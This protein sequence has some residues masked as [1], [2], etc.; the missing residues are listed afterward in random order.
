MPGNRKIADKRKAA[1][2]GLLLLGGCM[3]WGCDEPGEIKIP[4]ET[5]LPTKTEAP[6]PTEA[7]KPAEPEPTAALTGGTPTP[8]L[9]E[10]PEPTPTAEP[11]VTPTEKLVLSATPLPTEIQ[12]PTPVLTPAG[13]P[14]ALPTA[15][16]EL[17][18]TAEPTS[19]PEYDTLIR[20]GWQRAEDFFEN[21]EIYFS[22]MFDCVE[23]FASPGRYEYRYT[24]RADASVSFSMI[25]EEGLLVHSFLEELLFQ[26]PDC[27]FAAE[28]E[29]DYVYRYTTAEGQTVNGR[30]YS[31]T[32]GEQTNC[33]RVE[34]WYP[35]E[36]EYYGSEGYAFY[37]K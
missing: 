8:V 28:G 9:T 1:Y 2:A 11:E 3:L 36:N 24:V 19:C 34:L 27:V 35:A 6:Q 13:E 17:T 23:L 21:R 7:V 30:A 5:L 10:Q 37:L 31:C 32:Q 12:E 26:Y 14:V 18:P 4:T 29:A 20:N 22:G 25:G 16:P 33:M 15:A